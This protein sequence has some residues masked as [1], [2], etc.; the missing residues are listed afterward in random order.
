ML[1][2]GALIHTWNMNIVNKWAMCYLSDTTPSIV[3]VKRLSIATINLWMCVW[4]GC[5]WLSW[6][7][8]TWAEFSICDS[9]PLNWPKIN[10]NIFLIFG[11]IFWN[12]N[13]KINWNYPYVPFT[14]PLKLIL[15]KKLSREDEINFHQIRQVQ[16]SASYY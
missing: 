14:K 1:V 12:Y 6:L 9:V 3:Y 7:H 13:I 16:F 15:C 8:L 5:W 4:N 2:A 11:K 10:R